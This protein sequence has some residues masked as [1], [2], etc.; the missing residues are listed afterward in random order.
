[1]N[2]EAG[3]T[4]RGTTV[5]VGPWTGPRPEDPRS[6]AALLAHGDRRNDL[7]IGTVVCTANAFLAAEVHVV[8]RPR[9]NRRARLQIATSGSATLP[10]IPRSAKRPHLPRSGR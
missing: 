2:D 6:D 8:G 9:W 7:N 3:P 4:E 5:G 10:C 1:M